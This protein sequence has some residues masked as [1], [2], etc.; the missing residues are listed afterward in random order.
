MISDQMHSHPTDAIYV[1]RDERQRRELTGIEELA[2]SMAAIGQIHPVVIERDGR[3]RT[4]ERRWTAAKSLGWTNI[5]VR[6]ADELSEDELELLELDENIKRVN[7]PWEDECR[8][9][10]KYHQIRVRQD[11]TWTQA[12]T[13]EQLNM[14]RQTVTD[15]LVVAAELEAGN[16]RVMSSPKFSTARNVVQR[17][18]ERAAASGIKA[19]LA[20]TNPQKAAEIAAPVVPL[21]NVDFHEWAEA[22]TG[23]PFN[24]IHCDFPYGVNADKMAQGQAAELGGYADGFEV[25]ESLLITLK[26]SMDKIVDESAHLIFWFSMDYYQYTLECLTEM[27]WK[28]NLFPLV[29]YKDDNTGILPDP[30]RGPRRSYETAFFAS[31]GDRKLTGRGAVSN[32]KAWPGR[33]KSIHMSEKPVGML[34]HFFGMVVDEYSR[35]L[36][37]TA[38]SAN[39][40]KAASLLGAASV[41]G[42][43]RDKE[44][45]NRASEAYFAKEED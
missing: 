21:L 31:R 38:G 25:Y 35:V 10:L 23:K 36:D 12:Q 15:R 34:K 27:G 32:T 4:G 9:I 30:Q 7:L 5:L 16:E 29:W 11:S 24:F 26:S 40:L 37:P 2:T 6:F 45:F 1:V 18:N 44:F 14:K 28:V 20:A 19:A 33:D 13:A 41:L 22:Y 42:L 8:A 3:L 43:E 39:A 17:V